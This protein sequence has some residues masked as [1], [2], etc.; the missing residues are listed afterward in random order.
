MSMT[1]QDDYIIVSVESRKGGVGK[2]TVVLNMAKLLKERYHVLVLDVDVTGTSINAIEGISVWKKSVKLLKAPKGDSINLLQFFKEQYL[3]GSYSMRFSE[4]KVP[5]AVQVYKDYVNV[6]GSEL[7]SEQ[8]DMLYDPSIIFDEIHDYWLLDMIKKIARSF[9]DTFSDGK[10]SVVI[11]DN[12]PGY[13]GLG[14]SIHDL[15][16][17]LGPERGKFLSVSSL[18]IQD[19]DSCLK[20]VKNI[21]TLIQQKERGASFY[22][23][24]GG[25][26]LAEL[27]TGTVE[28]ETFDRLAIGDEDLAFYAAPEHKSSNIGKYQALVFNKVPLNVKNG[29]LVYQY[30][31]KDNPTLWDMFTALCGKNPHK[32]MI[33]YDES[34]HYQFFKNNLYLP[35]PVEDTKHDRLEKQ[36]ESLRKRAGK[37]DEYFHNNEW[38]RI[39]YSITT[40][41]RALKHIPESLNEIGLFDQAS[42][43]NPAWFPENTFRTM[44][45]YLQDMRIV[46]NNREFYFPYFLSREF[47]FERYLHRNLLDSYP[48]IA[49]GVKAIFAVMDT[50]I[51]QRDDSMPLIVQNVEKVLSMCLSKGMTVEDKP[52]QFFMKCA[53]SLQNDSYEPMQLFLVSFLE[54]LGRIL[55]FSEDIIII[56]TSI[57]ALNSNS[58]DAV[59]HADANVSWVID[60]KIITK[61]YNFEQAKETIYK[62]ISDSD[63]M[64]I[65][66]QVIAPIIDKWG[67]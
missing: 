30:K 28:Q 58:R 65:V 57:E 32:Y 11:L 66:R 48:Q 20:A 1:K 62:E 55:D 34:I 2:T 52:G 16:T 23:E 5:N 38:R 33:P 4:E 39:A 51:R 35:K 27:K 13:V 59:I 6:I 10:K 24:T 31:N 29:A 47:V 44:F 19:I 8:G 41:N 40:L 60:K 18:D 15:L 25:E 53:A 26:N 54:T 37:L 45:R 3:L 50:Y 14:R 49:C 12:S 63:Y 22:H 64:A 7:Y 67:L 42:H 43:I 17:D 56:C 9:S 36:L 46:S 61:E 21:H